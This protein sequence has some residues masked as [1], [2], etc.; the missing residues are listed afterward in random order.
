MP[1]APPDASTIVRSARAFE[2][3]AQ[4]VWPMHRMLVRSRLAPRCRRCALS[5]RREP[6]DGQGLCGPCR[7]AAASARTAAAG[8]GR[9]DRSPP[10][11]RLLTAYQGRGTGSHDALLLFSGG[12]DSVYMLKR[13]RDEHPLLRVL[14]L[15]IDNTFMSPIA[16]DN[17]DRL[18][19][20]IDVD[21][22]MVRHSRAFM[23]QLFRYCLTHLNA[24]GG[25]GTVDFSDG[26]LILD[27]ARRVA[28]EQAI[29]LILCGYS[30]YQ[31]ENGLRLNDFE[32][33][34]ERELIDRVQTA[35]IPLTDI[36]SGD[37][38]RTWWRA[39]DFEAGRVARMIFPMCAWDLEEDL[40]K[41]A[42][43][44][45]G[46]MRQGY[47][48]PIVTNHAL[49]PLIGVVDVHQLG[50]SSFEVEFCRMIR[51]GKAD[52]QHWQNVFEL[53]EYTSRT[54]MFVR[55]PVLQGLEML[56]LTLADVGVSFEN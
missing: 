37:A 18:I 11:H 36:A 14:A 17:I 21:H 10:L 45:W 5:S 1:S 52:R 15:S 30:R 33:P 3:Y 8:A 55:P 27:T 13:I 29:P 42:V 31:V 35:G 43:R 46:L 12:K 9:V 53:L 49:I 16:R 22:I 7:T 32:S 39:S 41:A 47:D 2:F 50:Y 23:A 26:E 38:L 48:S 51:D 34:R 54:G 20:R 24:D 4:R 6:L 56:G 40:V 44:A 25:Y 28:A 19:A